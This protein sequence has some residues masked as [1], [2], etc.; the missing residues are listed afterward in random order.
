MMGSFQLVKIMTLENSF[1]KGLNEKV[2][3]LFMRQIQVDK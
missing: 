1:L 3:D 2:D